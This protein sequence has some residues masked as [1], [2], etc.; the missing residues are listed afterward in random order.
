[1]DTDYWTLRYILYFF[2]LLLSNLRLGAI[3]CFQ[4]LICEGILL[5]QITSIMLYNE[6]SLDCLLFCL[7][8]FLLVQNFKIATDLVL[9]ERETAARSTF[10]RLV[11][12]H[13]SIFLMLI[14]T[15]F[16]LVNTT[17]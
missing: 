12:T 9:F 10:V 17:V 15:C 16:I 1:M 13:D 7:P 5:S 11:G 2:Y 3:D 6:M 8:A 4:L 14:Y